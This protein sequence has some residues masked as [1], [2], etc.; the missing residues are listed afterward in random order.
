MNEHC[1]D[2]SITVGDIGA[3]TPLVTVVPTATIAE[4]RRITARTGADII[5]VDG[6][7]LLIV[8]RDALATAVVDGAD[9][10][11]AITSIAGVP[12]YV[13]VHRELFDVVASMA[14]R[15]VHRALVIDDEAVVLGVLRLDDAVAALLA[16]PQWVGALRV[17]LHI[18]AAR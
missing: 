2:R 1:V 18:E 8:T 13:A 15:R 10:Q 7:P 11:C 14:A 16:G 5:A 17:A 6:D 3:L 4:C 9:L 12:D